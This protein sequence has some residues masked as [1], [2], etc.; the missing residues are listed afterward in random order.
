MSENTKLD[1]ATLTAEEIHAATTKI[2]ADPLLHRFYNWSVHSSRS[3]FAPVM[4]KVRIGEC[5]EC[6]QPTSVRL[7]DL[8]TGDAVVEDGGDFFCAE[9]QR[10]LRTQPA[11]EK[12]ECPNCGEQTKKQREHTM[13][14]GDLEG[15]AYTCTKPAPPESAAQGTKAELPKVPVFE[16]RWASQFLRTG[17]NHPTAL[18]NGYADA[19]D[20]WLA[21]LDAHEGKS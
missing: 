8:C 17:T 18:K 2:L 19:I 4:E 16:I 11:T 21:E 12:A 5:G 9:H 1:P 20:A 6:G 7:C 15:F 14:M 3:L 10:G 13:W